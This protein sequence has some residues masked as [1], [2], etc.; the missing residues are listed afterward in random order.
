MREKTLLGS[1]SGGTYCPGP[2]YDIRV[3]T[4]P[5][6]ALV[7]TPISSDRSLSPSPIL[8]ATN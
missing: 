6:H 7:C 4:L 8:E 5:P 1:S 3:W 2:A